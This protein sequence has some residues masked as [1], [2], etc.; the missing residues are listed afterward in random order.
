MAKKSPNPPD[1]TADIEK[2]LKGCRRDGGNPIIGRI[3]RQDNGQEHV[4]AIVL[5][6]AS[7]FHYN[8]LSKMQVALAQYLHVDEAKIQNEIKDPL[9]A[10]GIRL[11]GRVIGWGR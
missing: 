4:L 3:A 11:G 7:P 2:L 6:D 8:A 10:E 1:P 9:V 5:A